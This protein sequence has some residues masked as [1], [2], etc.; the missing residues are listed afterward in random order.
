M[1]K[2]KKDEEALTCPLGRFFTDLEHA[3]GSKSEFY[4]H[5]SQSR[6]EFLKAV[7]SLI[8]ERIENLDKRCSATTRK[9]MT[10]IKVE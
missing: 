3:F 6:I 2:K 4:K 9:K 5:L 7:R 8:D 10:K 1:A